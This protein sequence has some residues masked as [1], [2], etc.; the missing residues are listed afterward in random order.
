MMMAGYGYILPC[1]M[2]CYSP[3]C[4]FSFIFMAGTIININ[5]KYNI[6]QKNQTTWFEHLFNDILSYVC[7]QTCRYVLPSNAT[8]ADTW[9]P[10]NLLLPPIVHLPIPLCVS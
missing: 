7:I 10:L 9:C 4:Q 5:L 6:I 3:Y 8:C 1:I 2:L